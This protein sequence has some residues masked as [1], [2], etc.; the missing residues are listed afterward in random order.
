MQ[1]LRTPDV[2]FEGLEGYPY[3][4]HYTD[5]DGI[6]MHHAEVGPATGDAVLLLHGE[7]TWSYLYRHMLPPFEAAGYRALAPD[8]VGFGRS[9]KPAERDAYSYNVHVAWMKRWVEL[10]DLSSITL[11]CQDWGSLIGLRL[12]GE[13]PERFAR[14][15]VA[16]GFLPTTDRPLPLIFKLWQAF[17]RWSPFFPVGAIV[18][19]GCVNGLT[20]AARRGYEAPFPDRRFKAAARAFPRLVPAT[21]DDPAAAAN[22]AAWDVLARWERPLLTVF[23]AGDPIFRNLDR[24]LQRRVPGASGQPHR[25]LHNAGHFIQEDAGGELAQIIIEWMAGGR[26]RSD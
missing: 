21:R 17:A 7:P 13:M 23:G 12:V 18:R 14:V 19:A 22:A 25:V 8:L 24:V 11:V 1:I 20:R 15:V 26:D 2:R 6:R 3:P 9:D 5:V 16:N 4:P 10:N